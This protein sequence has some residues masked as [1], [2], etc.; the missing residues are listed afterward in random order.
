MLKNLALLRK[1]NELT[2]PQLAAKLNVSQAAVSRWEKGTRVPS[3]EQIMNLSHILNCSVDYLIGR[4]EAL[5]YVKISSSDHNFLTCFHSL[6]KKGQM[7]LLDVL[8]SFCKDE[9]LKK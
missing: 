4:T 3:T 7:L 9:A 1:Q 5:S 6:N 2:Q 8:L